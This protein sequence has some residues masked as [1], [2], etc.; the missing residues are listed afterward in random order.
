MGAPFFPPSH[1]SG[2]LATSHELTQAAP[3][4]TE[5]TI[6]HDWRELGPDRALST[7]GMNVR[8]QHRQRVLAA[9]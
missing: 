3:P 6:E 5:A 1:T 9:K 4:N 7:D 2:T 8:S